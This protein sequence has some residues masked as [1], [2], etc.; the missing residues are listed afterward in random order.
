[1]SLCILACLMPTDCPHCVGYWVGVGVVAS[2]LAARGN[3]K[4]LGAW[5]FVATT[6]SL[7]TAAVVAGD[8]VKYW[9]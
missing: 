4:A 7:N 2:Y 8:V 1:M 6:L 3:R 5:R 9:D